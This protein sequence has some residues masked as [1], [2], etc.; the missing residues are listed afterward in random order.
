[1]PRIE[2]AKKF[3]KIFLWLIN[4]DAKSS[5]QGYTQ[6]AEKIN[7]KAFSPR[8]FWFIKLSMMGGIFILIMAFILSY[9]PQIMRLTPFG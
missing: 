5:Y 4:E 7:K 3:F 6:H 8:V 2:S 9:F 1:M